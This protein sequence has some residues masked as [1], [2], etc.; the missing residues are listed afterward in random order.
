MTLTIRSWFN[1]PGIHFN[2]SYKVGQLVRQLM[3]NDIMTPFGLETKDPDI[4]LGLVIA[5]SSSTSELEVRGPDYD[6][7]NK[8]IN[9]GLWLP[10]S[11]INESPDYLKE[12]L[13]NL[14][15]ALVLLFSKYNIPE[16]A[17]RGVQKKVEIEVLNNENYIY[18]E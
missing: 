16:M 14:F 17:I 8:F 7:R 12:Y 5:T 2:I 18:S 10:Y 4:F 9:Y 15:D 13:S 1:E 3:S 6:K 11:K